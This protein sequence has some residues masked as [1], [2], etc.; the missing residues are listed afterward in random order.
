MNI[1]MKF[2]SLVWWIRG[3]KWMTDVP[4]FGFFLFQS[5]VWWIRGFKP[6]PEAEEAIEPDEFQS[7][8][9]WIRGFKK[10]ALKS[11]TRAKRRFNP[12]FGG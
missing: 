8:V 4:G 1:E 3:F 9:W 5:L 10:N 2:Q 11:R 6:A 12:W 7:L